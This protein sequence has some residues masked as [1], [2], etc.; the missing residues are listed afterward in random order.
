VRVAQSMDQT[1]I[2]SKA[3]ITLV[4][5]A[6]NLAT[7]D[8]EQ[9]K[10]SYDFNPTC[11]TFKY[12][13]TNTGK[14]VTVTSSNAGTI[15]AGTPVTVTQT[16]NWCQA[17][18]SADNTLT[19]TLDSENSANTSR[20]ATVYVTYKNCNSNTFTV[21]QESN[22][23]STV[24]IGGVQW[25]EY[26]L[27]NPKQAEGG[28]T[29]ATKLPSKCTDNIRAESHGKFYQWN[30]NVAWN[31]TGSSA[32]GAT[33]SGP[34]QTTY[35]D[36]SSWETSP[37]PD[38]FRLPTSAEFSDLINK[39]GTV[40]RGGGWN[41]NYGYLIVTDINDPDKF[42]EF[43]AVGQR[44]YSSDALEYYGKY[45]YYWA[46]DKYDSSCAYRMSFGSSGVNTN[47][48]LKTFGFSVRCVRQ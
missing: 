18:I 9:K 6:G 47:Y 1:F 42:L 45:G 2:D 39:N 7:C 10:V 43:P 5:V 24:T 44:N 12:N 16:G 4:G 32:S 8:I 22:G 26:N 40:T 14:T 11:L 21:T 37:C 33:P 35:P 36:G 19:V 30:R 23:P 25:T 28:A 20:S 13:E 38:G 29:F 46:S 48:A 3:K 27:A 34:W 41:D 17:E 15:P 31:T